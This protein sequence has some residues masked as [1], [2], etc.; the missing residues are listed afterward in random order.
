M[1]PDCHQAARRVMMVIPLTMRV[2]AQ[3]LRQLHQEVSR[4]HF[5]LLTILAERPHNLGELADKQ[6]VSAPT[7]SNTITHL[8]DKGW[9]RRARNPRDRRLVMVEL[10]EAGREALAAIDR[11]LEERLAGALASLS[12]PELAQ[13]CAGL[14]LLRSCFDRVHVAEPPHEAEEAP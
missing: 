5:R 8:E 10:T 9:V 1:S 7:M 2:L 6:W 3:D 14:D 13:I 11:V 4:G 12:A